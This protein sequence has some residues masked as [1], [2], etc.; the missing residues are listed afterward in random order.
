MPLLQKITFYPRLNLDGRKRF[1]RGRLEGPGLFRLRS[2]AARWALALSKAGLKLSLSRCLVF[3]GEAYTPLFSVN[4]Y[5][6]V[7]NHFQ[8]KTKLYLNLLTM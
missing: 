8:Y 5:V 2:G 1:E 3:V 4:I 6:K 7:Q